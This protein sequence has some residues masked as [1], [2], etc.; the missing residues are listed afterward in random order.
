MKDLV[1]LAADNNLES[2][3]K[4]MLGR[5]KSMNIRSVDAD[6]FVHPEHDPGCALRGV[7]YLNRPRFL[8][9]YRY[10]LV[11]FDHEGSGRESLSPQELQD[12]VNTEFARSEWGERARAVVVVPELEAWVWSDSPHV[13]EVAGWKNGNT[14]L[15]RWLQ[16][17][18]WLNEGESKPERPKAAFESALRAAKKR[19]SSSLYLQIAQRVSLS[20]CEDRAFLEFKQIMRKWFPPAD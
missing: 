2:A 18:G 16:E 4:G 14:R 19:R 7:E 8:N 12:K 13:A 20:R 1:I 11:I 17:E 15:R 9:Q 5:Y 10:G 3:L 6:F